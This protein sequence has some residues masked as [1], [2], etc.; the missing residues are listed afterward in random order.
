MRTPI[1]T[2]AVVVL[3]LAG[4]SHTTRPLSESNLTPGM[5]KMTIAKGRTTQ[6]QVMEVFG[7]P[8]LV[9]HRDDLQIWTYDKIRYDV[10]SSSGFLYVLLAGKAG[11][12]RRSASTSTMLIVYFDSNDVVREYRM[13]TTRF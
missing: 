13:N 7:P 11:Q 10:E 6:A 3:L 4:C 5:A 9:T 1:M 8:D 12:S 2:A